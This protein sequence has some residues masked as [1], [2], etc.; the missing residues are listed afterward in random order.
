MTQSRGA[1][2]KTRVALC[3]EQC[4][5]RNYKT[6]RPSKDGSTPLELKKYCKHCKAHTIHRESR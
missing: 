5:A 1:V 4:K 2:A 6:T 3:C